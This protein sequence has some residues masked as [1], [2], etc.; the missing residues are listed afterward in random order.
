VHVYASDREYGAP[1]TAAAGA[2]SDYLYDSA[3]QAQDVIRERV[4]ASV[5]HHLGPGFRV[6]VDLI[7]RQ[8]VELIAVILLVGSA[9]MTYG[10][11]RQGLDYIRTDSE[12]VMRRTLGLFGLREV[13]ADVTLGPA[14][15]RFAEDGAQDVTAPQPSEVPAAAPPPSGSPTTKQR[16][17][18]G[19]FPSTTYLVLMVSLVIAVLLTLLLVVVLVQVL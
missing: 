15:S 12:F 10:A 7:Q 1:E 9:I 18:P 8:S 4:R 6:E 19:G 14:L 17:Q 5:S 3:T 11:V 2:T 16:P 13:A